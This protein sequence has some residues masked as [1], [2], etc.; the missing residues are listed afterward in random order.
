MTYGEQLLDPKWDTIR[1]MIRIRDNQTCQMCGCHGSKD[2]PLNVHH[3]YYKYGALAWEY[4]NDALT[5]LCA[6][7]HNLI[8]Q[9]IPPLCYYDNGDRLLIMNFT[10]C[11]RCDGSGWLK[12]YLYYQNGI[13]FRCYGNRYEEL[14]PKNEEVKVINVED[15]I[16]HDK[17]SF[18]L[19]NPSN[20][21]NKIIEIFKIGQ[22]YYWEA[23]EG[24]SNLV[25]AYRLLHKAALNGYGPAQNYCGLVLYK[26]HD[27]KRALR[28][29]AYSAMQGTPQAQSNLYT[30]LS[31]GV[32][33]TK[34][35]FD[36]AKKWLIL[37]ESNRKNNSIYESQYIPSDGELG[38]E[39]YLKFMDEECE[40]YLR[41][42]E[43]QET[44]NS[45]TFKEF[46]RHCGASNKVR[47]FETYQLE[48]RSLGGEPSIAFYVG[49]KC[50]EIFN[51]H[52]HFPV[53]YV[54]AHPDEFWVE[55]QKSGYYYIHKGEK[56]SLESQI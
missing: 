27:F 30:I 20:N 54:A 36:L 24:H 8:H 43:S 38:Y 33:Y 4:N 22:N 42:R 17:D 26:Q 13:C 5:T 7:C 48:P 51:Y 23:I 55:Q 56:K 10:P 16:I 2:N 21:V 1:S 28:W 45:W 19:L 9:T 18:D 15:F 37:S 34:N 47:I 52:E 25:K 32:G 44:L 49:E 14:I 6:N 53:E 11:H 35:D 39:D 29:F 31:T 50:I 41:F 46:L 3:R 12:E 40:E